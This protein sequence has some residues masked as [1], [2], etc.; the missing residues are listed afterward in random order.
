M[1]MPI[2]YE[3][4]STLHLGDVSDTVEEFANEIS[5]MEGRCIDIGCGPGNVSA[6]LILPKLPP[7]AKLVGA[8]ISTP[9]IN[10]ARRK[11][12]NE[13]RLCFVQLDIGMANLS[14]EEVGQYD[15]ALSF[16]CLHWV[17]DSRQAFENIYKLLRAGGK[18]LV[19]LISSRIC[20]DA[21]M[22][23]YENPRYRPY[24][25]DV[26]CFIP[27]FHRC[28]DSRA[29]L[30]KILEEVGFEVQHCSRREKN[31]VF[32]NTEI[33][34]NQA[35][36]VNPFISRIPEDLK[37]EYG[38]VLLKEMISGMILLPKDTDGDQRMLDRYQL[39]VA[40][41]KKPADAQ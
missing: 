38:D 23:M 18:A 19:T 20:F 33:L 34:R 37:A 35:L 28:N 11:Y 1:F 7:Q 13:K 6:L 30:R 21:Y 12:R 27:P 8:D 15:N 2:E 5:K 41:V 29:K 26:H 4:A 31:F 25:Q 39:L 32:Q 16:Y 17:H 22:R 10:H 3:I 14:P 9:M 40:Y 36:S 24:M